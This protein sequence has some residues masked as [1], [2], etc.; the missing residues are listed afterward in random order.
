[1]VKHFRL[2]LNVASYS[3]VREKS[4]LKVFENSLELQRE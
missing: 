1:M 4:R 3:L 2:F